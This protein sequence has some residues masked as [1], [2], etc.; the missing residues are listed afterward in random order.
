MNKLFSEISLQEQKMSGQIFDN[1]GITV[2]LNECPEYMAY[3]NYNF[4]PSW[5]VKKFRRVFRKGEIARLER[6]A[7]AA[8]MVQVLEQGNKKIT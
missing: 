2:N 4:R 1:L 5:I 3:H 8:F 6:L 7:D